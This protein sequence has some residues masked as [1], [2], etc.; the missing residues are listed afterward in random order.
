MKQIFFILNT[1]I[2]ILGIY[3]LLTNLYTI[4]WRGKLIAKVKESKG[5]SIFWG[6]ALIFWVAMTW[7]GISEYINYKD[8]R[9][10]NNIIVN[11]FW[12]ESSVLNLIMSVRSA[13][14]RENGIY[15]SGHFYNWSK[16]KDYSW[17]S[18]NVIQFKISILFKAN[19]SCEFTIKEEV[20]LKVNEVMQ[21]N[22]EL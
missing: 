10:I 11:I 6:V 7:F 19:R 5:L 13:E 17:I 14:I 3:L 9:I 21:R 2:I 18:E 22:F 4:Y 8:S 15:K 16:I 20:K 12:V 1:V